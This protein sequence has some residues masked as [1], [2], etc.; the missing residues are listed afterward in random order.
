M[1]R[2]PTCRRCAR[3]DAL[4][5]YIIDDEFVQ[6]CC[7]C[8][9]QES[10]GRFLDLCWN[11]L[12]LLLFAS[13]SDADRSLIVPITVAEILTV[14]VPR[15]A[16]VILVYGFAAEEITVPMTYYATLGWLE[17]AC[18]GERKDFQAVAS[19]ENLL[20]AYE[21]LTRRVRFHQ[22][23]P[24]YATKDHILRVASSGR[25]PIASGELA[26]QEESVVE[27][28]FAR[29]GGE[30]MIA[31]IIR[32]YWRPSIVK[33]EK[34]RVAAVFAAK[35]AEC[36]LAE[37]KELVEDLLRKEDVDEVSS[38]FAAKIASAT[39][40]SV[41]PKRKVSVTVCR[42]PSL[43]KRH[44]NLTG[45]AAAVSLQGEAEEDAPTP[46]PPPDSPF[47][48]AAEPDEPLG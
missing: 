47:D 29:L 18:S 11:A 45:A 17:A 36:K 33:E 2:V 30:K 1:D 41:V 20:K 31:E 15:A 12:H 24:R 28:V 5:A 3:T 10:S 42:A 43:A 35:A 38:A 46:P 7:P 39:A 22:F 37:R 40:S 23:L 13:A 4:S 32:D 34:A 14:A 16:R 6:L 27:L 8:L 21:G 26:F 25:P 44:K 48:P 19:G 9:L